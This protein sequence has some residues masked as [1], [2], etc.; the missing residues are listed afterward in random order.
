MSNTVLVPGKNAAARYQ[1]HVCLPKSTVE[2]KDHVKVNPSGLSLTESDLGYAKAHGLQKLID[3]GLV[4]IVGSKNKVSEPVPSP[5]SPAVVEMLKKEEEKAKEPEEKSPS[6]RLNVVQ[7]R[8][9]KTRLQA[10][11]EPALETEKTEE[12]ETPKE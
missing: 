9:G 4:A 5:K 11:A 7:E 2:L 3:E 1:V 6:G 12:V 8:K 10:A